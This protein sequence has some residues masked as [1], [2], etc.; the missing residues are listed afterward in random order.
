MEKTPKISAVTPEQLVQLLKQAG[1]R[2]ITEE[3][4]AADIEAGCPVNEDGTLS[5]ID[6]AVWL[7]LG[8]GE[9]AGN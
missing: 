6:Y 8:T 9:N 2:T 7:M 3:T 5:L 1:S 4:L